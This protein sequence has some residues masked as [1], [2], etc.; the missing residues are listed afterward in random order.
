M[1]RKDR[2][3]KKICEIYKSRAKKKGK[4]K[5]RKRLESGRG[6]LVNGFLWGRGQSQPK[7]KDK[8]LNAG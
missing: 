3:D 5:C 4:P 7:G 6:F 2:W 8:T 1:K